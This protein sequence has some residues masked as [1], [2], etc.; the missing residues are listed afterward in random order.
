MRDQ[1]KV[2]SSHVHVFTCKMSEIVLAHF[3]L[4]VRQFRRAVREE[5]SNLSLAQKPCTVSHNDIFK[6]C[7]FF[8]S[9][10]VCLPL[11]F[12]NIPVFEQPSLINVT[13]KVVFFKASCMFCLEAKRGTYF[14]P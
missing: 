6:Y 1:N 4:R 12:A 11:V 2:I 9:R 10:F 5:D 3:P 13:Q 7:F 8:P 14:I